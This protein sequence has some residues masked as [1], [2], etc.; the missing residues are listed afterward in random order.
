MANAQELQEQG[1]KLFQQRDYEAAARIFQQAQEA[2]AGD[3]QNDMA[4][5]MKTNIGL[6]H[7]SLGENQQALES[8]QDALQFFQGDGDQLRTAK[9]LGNMGGVYVALGDKEQAYNC[10]RQAADL[11]QE[12]G[13]KTLYGETLVAMGD[14]QFRDGKIM[15]GAATYEV[16][17]ENLDSLS[18]TQRV[19][20]GI[21]GLRNKLMGGGQ[22][23]SE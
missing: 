1:V 19:L 2:Y 20:K 15:A 4:A 8:M 17:L 22:P 7:R 12:L 3:G 11:F 10:Y 14:L 16:G 21:M 6:V 9:V 13:E 18:P 23:S 5:E